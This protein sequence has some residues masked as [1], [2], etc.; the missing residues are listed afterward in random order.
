[1]KPQACH[2][3]SMPKQTG[4]KANGNLADDETAIRRNWTV[5]NGDP[6]VHLH[7]RQP[8]PRPRPRGG[9]ERRLV[10]HRIAKLSWAS[11]PEVFYMLNAVARQKELCVAINVCWGD[12]RE[13]VCDATEDGRSSIS[14]R[15]SWLAVASARSKGDEK[16]GRNLGPDKL[17]H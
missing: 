12:Q 8:A 1:M 4:V 17:T 2:G 3:R 15:S 9:E 7:I 16:L 14:S 10:P 6:L 5:R 11:D 13:K